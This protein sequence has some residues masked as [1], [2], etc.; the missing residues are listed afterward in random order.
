LIWLGELAIIHA[1]GKETDGNY[2]MVELYA[3]KEGEVPWHIHHNEDEAFYILDG[4][5]TFYIGDKMVKGKTGDCVFAP[6]GIPHRYSVDTK[7]YTK[8][9]MVFSPAGFE[10]FVRAT[11]VPATSLVPPPPKEIEMDFEKL[12]KTAMEFGA[13]F[14]E[15]PF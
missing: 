2:S 15:S 1:T 6:K 13:E 3:T 5:M 11:S 14:V 4:E 12:K 7:G 9:M 10:D 8:V